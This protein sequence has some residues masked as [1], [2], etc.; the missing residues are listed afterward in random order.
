M[1]IFIFLY[2]HIVY[3]LYTLWF[4]MHASLVQENLSYVGNLDGMH[5]YFIIWAIMCETA[6]A[7]G[8]QRC[9]PKCLHAKRLM[10]WIVISALLFLISVILPYFPQSHPLSAQ[11]HIALS[12][13]GLIMILVV[14]IMMVISLCFSYTIFPYDYLLILID[15]IALGIYGAHHMSV[16]SLVEVFL[17][18]TLP[19]YL[20]HLRGKI[21]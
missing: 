2:L 9:L 15:G 12:F 7:L 19:I 10:P 11:F 21:S 20:Y 16:N 1:K 3:P 13:I 6:L 18:I 8:F 4:A 14:I 17:G 5:L